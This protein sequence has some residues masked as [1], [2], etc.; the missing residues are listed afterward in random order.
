MSINKLLSALISGAFLAST[1][2]AA[3][4]KKSADSAPAATAATEKGAK[5]KAKPH[6]HMAEGGRGMPGGSGT[7][8]ADKKTPL[9]DHKKEHKQQ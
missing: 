2:D 7:A 9:H 1:A 8:P 4:E 3:D 6:N 5:P